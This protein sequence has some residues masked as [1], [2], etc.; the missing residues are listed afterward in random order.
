MVSSNSSEKIIR[1][2]S[3]EKI[4]M[5]GGKAHTGGGV[6]QAGQSICTIGPAHRCDTQPDVDPRGSC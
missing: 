5:E 2:D 4:L 6:V 1:Q 3:S